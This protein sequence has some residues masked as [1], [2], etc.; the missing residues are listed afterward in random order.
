[1]GLTLLIYLYRS[2]HR[3]ASRGTV[4]NL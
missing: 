2:G 4:P 1:M 3:V